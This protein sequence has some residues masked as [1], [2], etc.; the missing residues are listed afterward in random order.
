[1]EG[2]VREDKVEGIRIVVVHKLRIVVYL[3]H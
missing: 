3:R 1:M 2:L